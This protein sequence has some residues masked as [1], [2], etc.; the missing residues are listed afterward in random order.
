MVAENSRVRRSCGRRVEDL[1]EILAK[2]HVEHLV[3]LVEHRDARARRG[4][5]RRARDGR[6]A[7][8]GVPTTMW[9]PPR[10]R[11][12]LLRRV[13]A[14]DAGRDRARR[15]CRRAR[16]FAADL[17]RQLAGRRDRPGRAAARARTVAR[18]GLEQLRRRWRGRRRR[19]CPSRSGPRR[20]GRGRRPAVRG[21]RPGRASACHSRARPAPPPS[22][23]F[24]L[25]CC[26]G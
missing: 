16:Q 22:A 21:R 11:A 18:V 24:M 12:P 7:G 10:E 14:A 23:G 26:M 1:L 9:A 2:A 13:H 17:Q 15:P 20:S 8:P 4:R 5:A 19:S 6:A 25:G 3:G